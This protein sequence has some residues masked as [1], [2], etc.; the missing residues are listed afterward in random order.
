MF[1][2]WIWEVQERI[3]GQL[4][5]FNLVPMKKTSGIL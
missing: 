3:D 1:S 4:S 5:R 2:D